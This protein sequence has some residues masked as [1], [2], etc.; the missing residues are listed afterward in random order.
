MAALAHSQKDVLSL[1]CAGEDWLVVFSRQQGAGLDLS[2]T[3][4]QVHRGSCRNT[5][6][7]FT[8]HPG[9][10]QIRNTAIYQNADILRKKQIKQHKYQ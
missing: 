8:L 9:V 7:I 4:I 5:R 10:H 3:V 6:S 1:T 2:G